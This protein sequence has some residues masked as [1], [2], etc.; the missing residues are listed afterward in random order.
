MA[1]ALVICPCS[2]SGITGAGATNPGLVCHPS[3]T[4]SREVAVK[5]VGAAD[6]VVVAVVP[7][8][9]VLLAD[10]LADGRR[11]D[12]CNEVVRSPCS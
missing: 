7:A 4:P 1:V 10:L 5:V 12:L 11:Q 9:D 3:I 6:V 8:L 2:C